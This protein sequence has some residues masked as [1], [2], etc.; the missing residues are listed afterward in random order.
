MSEI[1][2]KNTRCVYHCSTKGM[3]YIL[4]QFKRK[5]IQNY[6]KKNNFILLFLSKYKI[7]ILINIFYSNNRK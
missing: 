3:W 7:E 1:T 4:K 6:I 2:Q 5:I